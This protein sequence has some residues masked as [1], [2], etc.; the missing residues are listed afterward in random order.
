MIAFAFTFPAGRYH[1]TP[2]GRNVNE[3]DVAWPPE[4]VRILRSLIATWWRKADQA[5]FPKAMLDSLI[6]ALAAEPPVFQLPDAV[7]THIRTFMPAPTKPPGTLIYDAFFRLDRAAE[8]I[9]AWPGIGLSPEQHEFAAHLLERMGY[10]GRAESWVD[11]RIA[12]NWDGSFNAAPR[13]DGT[14]PP[15]D[16]VPIDV[17]LPVSA[18]AWVQIRSKF[19][20]HPKPVRG[21]RRQGS[22]AESLPERL[23]DALSVDTSEW[24]EAGWSTPPIA[25]PACL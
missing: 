21:K 12:D 25:A 15:R 24:Q 14:V 18:N 16:S 10:L 1:A 3:A 22:N 8:L 5:H 4:P 9:V 23:C 11:G 20:E 19:V 17:T 2:W 6:D 7:H 13:V